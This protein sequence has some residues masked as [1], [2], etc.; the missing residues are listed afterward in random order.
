MVQWFRALTS[1]QRVWF[2]RTHMGWLT[3]TCRLWLQGIQHPLLLSLGTFTHA[4]L[5]Q[6]PKI[7]NGTKKASSINGAGLTG[8]LYVEE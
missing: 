8:C 3:T 1:F 6:M 4:A 7:Y 2:P 5:I